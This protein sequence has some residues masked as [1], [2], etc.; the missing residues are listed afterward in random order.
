MTPAYVRMMAAYGAW[1]NRRMP[2]LC[3]GLSAAQRARDMG[4][5]F[6]SIHGTFDQSTRP[7]LDGALHRTADADQADRRGPPRILANWMAS[8][9]AMDCRI[10]ARANQVTEAWLAETT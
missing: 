9:R 5:F 2:D 1:M 4:T 6:K 8:R 3:S 7:R 10:E